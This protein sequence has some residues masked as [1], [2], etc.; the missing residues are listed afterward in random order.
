[1]NMHIFTF[2]L[3]ASD[4]SS[5]MLWRLSKCKF[6]LVTV[7]VLICINKF[8]FSVFFFFASEQYC[9]FKL[10][11][12]NCFCFLMWHLGCSVKTGARVTELTYMNIIFCDMQTIKILKF[13]IPCILFTWIMVSFTSPLGQKKCEEKWR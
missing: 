10:N 3:F 11:I 1:M 4:L 13:I 12:L 8:C 6:F 9:Y 7:F 2:F 5:I